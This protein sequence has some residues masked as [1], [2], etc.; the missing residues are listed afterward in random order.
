MDADLLQKIGRLRPLKQTHKGRMA[1][2]GTMTGRCPASIDGK[3]R[4]SQ[5]HFSREGAR[6]RCSL[7]HRTEWVID[8]RPLRE[9]I[10]EM[11]GDPDAPML[12]GSW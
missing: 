9:E 1:F 3:H 5:F 4:V 6:E 8:L 2:E 7:C 11:G 12:G 10:R